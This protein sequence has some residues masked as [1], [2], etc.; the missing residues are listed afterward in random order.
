MGKWLST[1]HLVYDNLRHNR[2]DVFVVVADWL[3]VRHG[4]T[5]NGYFDGFAL[6]NGCFTKDDLP[7]LNAK[8][9]GNRIEIAWTK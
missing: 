4:L 5:V 6:V 3:A 2:R 8:I 7:P 9:N 1:L